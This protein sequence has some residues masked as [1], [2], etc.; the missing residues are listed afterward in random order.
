MGKLLK[1]QKPDHTNN[2]LNALFICAPSTGTLDSWVPVIHKLKDKYPGSSYTILFPRS[3]I[4]VDSDLDSSLIQFSGPLFNNVV[5]QGPQGSVWY[6]CD[7]FHKARESCISLK[8]KISHRNRALRFIPGR[9]RKYLF[10]T[11]KLTTK[12]SHQIENL[13]GFLNQFNA[14]FYDVYLHDKKYHRPILDRIENTP[15][16]S[17]SHGLNPR[18]TIRKKPKSLSNDKGI[19]NI[20]AF[21]YSSDEFIP[22]KQEMGLLPENIIV[23]GVPRHSPDWMKHFTQSGFEQKKAVTLFKEDFI[24]VISRKGNTPLLPIERMRKSI[25]WIK[26]VAFDV[27]KVK[28]VIKLHPKETNQSLYEEVLGKE[29]Y[30]KKWMFS[31]AHFFTIGKRS[32]FAVCYFSGVSVDLIPLNIPTIELLDIRGLKEHENR[33]MKDRNGVPVLNY[34]FNDLV[35][36][37]STR[38]EFLNHVHAVMHN[39]KDKMKALEAAYKKLY[40]DPKDSLDIIADTILKRS[41][42]DKNYSHNN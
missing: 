39:K 17:I 41:L 27:L 35:L 24:F 15:K 16:F 14:V 18:N 3:H 19:E 30:G 6:I 23:T 22:Y 34:R 31:N 2:R 12:E 4:L 10:N 7:T 38:S 28:V 29:E 13:Q 11:K 26:Y 5:F 21:L 1:G 40:S 33:G 36:G 8:E 9:F 32:L 37:A 42:H 20:T 25:E